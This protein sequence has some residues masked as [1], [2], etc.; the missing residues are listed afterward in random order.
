[1]ATFYADG[2]GEPVDE[3][4]AWVDV[5]GVQNAMRKSIKI[6]ANFVY[7]LHIALLENIR[8]SVSVYP[9]MDGAYFSS[10][11]VFAL[12]GVL[13]NIFIDIA[14]CFVKD[15]NAPGFQFIIKGGISYGQ[16]FHGRS[17]QAS[18]SPVLAQYPNHRDAIVLGTPVVRANQ[19][20]KNAPPFGVAI[21]GDVLNSPNEIISPYGKWWPWFGI[22]FDKK[23][24]LEHLESYYDF[25]SNN[26]QS[27]KYPA[28]R[29]A[30]HRDMARKYFK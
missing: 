13:E 26:W 21:D 12:F 20:E 15:A 23:A 29:I 6:T 25:Y 30:V 7:K 5:M 16:L 9:V 2:L 27:Q 18:C 8:P 11:D 19:V 28:D 17:L 14:S 1:M 24:F 3:Y 4:I 10:P 22:S